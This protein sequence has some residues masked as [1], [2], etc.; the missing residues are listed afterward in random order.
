VVPKPR[1]ATDPTEGPTDPHK[2]P[3][4]RDEGFATDRTALAWERMA[5]ATLAIA[6]IVIRQGIVN[7]PLGLAT[8]LAAILIGAALLQWRLSASLGPAHH[9]R[10]IGALAALTMLV[11]AA[12]FVIAIAG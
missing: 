3:T 6:A 2:S 5:I 1:P 4:D 10:Q 11:A 7:G 9:Y 12:A 8:P